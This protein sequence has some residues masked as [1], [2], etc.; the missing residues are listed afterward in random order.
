MAAAVWMVFAIATLIGIFAACTIVVV[1][2]VRAI[3]R[4][5]AKRRGGRGP[6]TTQ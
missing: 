5:L 1:I 4:K 2:G 6:I 3:E